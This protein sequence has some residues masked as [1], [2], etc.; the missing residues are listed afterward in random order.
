MHALQTPTNPN[1][2]FTI[3]V[4]INV[5]FRFQNLPGNVLHK[6]EAEHIG[7]FYGPMAPPDG[8]LEEVS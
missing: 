6:G 4:N 5:V 2:H 3:A 8:I 7:P 1:D